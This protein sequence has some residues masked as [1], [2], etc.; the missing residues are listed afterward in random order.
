M[1]SSF[2]LSHLRISFEDLIEYGKILEL[3]LS[4]PKVDI[5]EETLEG[6]KV[7]H[8]DE[9]RRN[10]VKKQLLQKKLIRTG[11]YFEDESYKMLG[12]IKWFGNEATGGEYGFVEVP[13]LG[14]VFFH[15]RCVV[16]VNK[17]DLSE[18]KVVVI[19]VSKTDFETPTSKISAIQVY[20]PEQE[21]DLYYIFSVYLS[22][23]K[24]DFSKVKNRTLGPEDILQ[25]FEKIVLKKKKK[26]GSQERD[27]LVGLYLNYI[28]ETNL[29][30]HINIFG[31]SLFET[32]YDEA[33]ECSFQEKLNELT[34]KV[35]AE[36]KLS[37]LSASLLYGIRYFSN[38]EADPRLN[39]IILEKTDKAEQ[40]NLWK[41]YNFSIPLAEF[42]IELSDYL[43]HEPE[44][45]RV[46]LV[47]L[48]SNEQQE[49]LNSSLQNSLNEGSIKE[50]SELLATMKALEVEINLD[51]LTKDAVYHL[52][53][54]FE[55]DVPFNFVKDQVV[56][57]ILNDP[58]SFEKHFYIRLTEEEIDIVLN[59]GFE[60]LVHDEEKIVKIEFIAEFI[61]LL[62]K[63]GKKFDLN[64]LG[65]KKLFELWV[66][67]LMNFFPVDAVRKRIIHLLEK[68]S[69]KIGEDGTIDLIKIANLKFFKKINYD[70]FINLFTSIFYGT[71]KVIRE[72]QYKEITFILD[73]V[74]TEQ[75]RIDLVNYIFSNSSEFYRLHLFIEDYIEEANFNEAVIYTGLLNT[76]KQKTFFK[77]LI[78]LIAEDKLN[79][80]LEDLNRITT[81]DYQLSEYSKE[82]D[83]VGLDYTL[84]VIIQLL[85][86][87]QQ[88]NITKQQT[89]YDLVAQQVKKPDDLLVIDG[90]FDRCEGRVVL[91]PI[92]NRKDPEN[93]EVYSTVKDAK[94]NP[95][96][97]SFCDGRKAINKK[98]SEP[99]KCQKSGK[100]FWWCE[101]AQCYDIS[102]KEHRAEDWKKYS[103]ADVMRVLGIQYQEEQYEKLLA[104]INRVN[105]F[106][107]HLTCRSCKTILRPVNSSD[108]SNYAF[109]RVTRF[110]CGNS[111]CEEHHNEIYLS[112]CLNGQ[113][114]DIIDSRD[115]VRCKPEGAKENCGWYICN[116][117]FACCSSEKI[118]GRKYI[119]NQTGQT[120]NCH[121]HGHKDMGKICCN[122]CGQ[123][124]EEKEQFGELFQKQL[125]WFIE[126]QEKGHP[127][128]ANSG[129]RKNDN[130]WWFLWSRGNYEHAQYRRQLKNMYFAGFNIP[131]FKDESNEIQL[132]AEPFRTDSSS[133]IFHCP[134]CENVLKI[135]DLE[136]FDYARQRSIYYYH[137]KIF[138][139]TKVTT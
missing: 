38:L 50:I 14:D 64:L 7:L 117:C 101:N 71:G 13:G 15:Y 3:D 110:H 126:H 83:G 114:L 115:S 32:L 111:T 130:K 23:Y 78:K 42:K 55:L 121:D 48:G 74:S 67:D 65:D 36:Y 34:R 72:S 8:N 25:E 139:R 75:R 11:A 27:Y 61:K 91:K 54:D 60:Q 136:E 85:N 97:A 1:R 79:I 109:Y 138:P 103:L 58:L 5:S 90:F 6:L 46:A 98:T 41:K 89:I 87:L 113:C 112:H 16:E 40:F 95:R 4:D 9:V 124:M 86:D 100:E 102:R 82:I 73:N 45:A 70:Q 66:R 19:K 30:V 28:L 53:K 22:I 104:V 96:F 37:N 56:Q 44:K 125:N 127:N 2:V 108:N 12:V 33:Y 29:Y 20:L 93:E 43:R 76:A 120:Y 24:S 123:E 10:E 131:D 63:S 17:K 51:F 128:I 84:S 129:R 47:T 26:I 69:R 35:I 80:S 105:R 52:W 118:N 132:V 31:I 68:D 99:S 62:E 137:D 77:K 49:I 59:K 39:E 106:L 92:E 88:G 134:N 81:I 107:S 135:N 119:M 122:K 116:N 21:E 18:N 133:R 94:R 57:D